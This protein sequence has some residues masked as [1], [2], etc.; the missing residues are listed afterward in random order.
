MPAFR[1]YLF[2]SSTRAWL[3]TMVWSS[4][5]PHSVNDMVD[6]AF[7]SH[8]DELIAIWARDTLGLEEKDY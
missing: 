3:D 8:K 6:K 5:Q 7:E 2:H 1:E 4:A